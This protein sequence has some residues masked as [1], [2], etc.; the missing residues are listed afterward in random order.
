MSEVKSYRLAKGMRWA[1]RIIG[2]VVAGLFLVFLIGETVDAVVS[3]GLAG[4][5]A[6]GFFVAAPIVIAA[7]G[8]ILSWWRV[9]TAGVLLVLA[10]LLSG[11]MPVFVGIFLG[12]GI[13][14]TE[15]FRAPSWWIFMLPFLV[16]GILLLISRALSGKAS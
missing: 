11:F 2:A 4:I 7:A 10:Y 6:E 15:V 3:E 12:R 5:R 1:A 13:M 9:G 8:S 14:P 16:A